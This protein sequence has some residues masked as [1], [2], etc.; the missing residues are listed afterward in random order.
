M[1]NMSTDIAT[2]P[3]TSATE[4]KKCYD[5]RSESKTALKPI[6]A[7][8][9]LSKEGF[10]GIESSFPLIAMQCA[11]RHLVRCTEFCL[12]CHDK[13]QTDFEAMRPYVCDSPLCLYQYMSLGFGPSVESDILTQ[14][15][16]VD[17]LV[18][19][20]YSAAEALKL[21][22]FP[23]GM[24]IL[25]PSESN[26]Q[27]RY[28]DSANCVVFPTSFKSP[29][30]K[31]GDWIYFT[32]CKDR[33]PCHLRVTEVYWPEVHVGP[34][35]DVPSVPYNPLSGSPPAHMVPPLYNSTRGLG[36]SGSVYIHN[37]A[38]DDMNIQ[39]KRMAIT[40]L[41]DL[42]PSVAEMRAW[43]K[44][45]SLSG[46]DASLKTWVD[47]ILPSSLNIL[48]W[49]IASNRSCIVPAGHELGIDGLPVTV[50]ESGSMVLGV[51]DC[52][53]FR[54][55]MGAPDKE[56]R[57]VN[58]VKEAR[59]RLNLSCTNP[60]FQFFSKFHIINCYRSDSFRF[61]RV[62]TAKLAFHRPLRT[63]LRI[64]S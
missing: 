32:R 25:V 24:N 60:F 28:I 41:L 38:F 22:T 55:A 53:Q 6:V 33:A 36:F 49:I 42:L 59:V 14:P 48:R 40:R 58:S 3:A 16:V 18:S 10:R 56:Q 8:D 9:A 30:V 39:M 51:R 35:I 5:I 26:H 43:L 13:I 4:F 15:T 45:N 64:H 57:F 61:P 17:L 29:L 31:V 23:T 62:S 27:A 1:G 7:A 12:V 46:L 52:L 50:G 47:R 54:F 19:F 34:P 11:L 20:C 63:S 44:S 2:F 37:G 21:Q